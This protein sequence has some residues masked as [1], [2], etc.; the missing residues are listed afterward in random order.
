MKHWCWRSA[1]SCLALSL[2]VGVALVSG[3]A[4]D[5]RPKLPP[6]SGPP[7][8][9]KNPPKPVK[10]PTAAPG[11]VRTP[12]P[13]APSRVEKL[14]E[15]TLRIGAIYVD[16]TKKEIVVPG[17]IN[18]VMVLE[19]LVNTK[20]G[21]KS[22]ESAIEADCTALDFNV[23]LVLIGLDDERSKARPRFHF[24]PVTPQGD[25]V[26]MSVSWRT[27]IGERH[28]KLEELIYNEGNKQTLPAGH[29]VY[30]G[31]RFM[32]NS[33]ALMADVDGVLIGFVHTPATLIERAE[34]VPGPYGNAKLNPALG[35]TAGTP[36]LVTIKALP[37]AAR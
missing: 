6:F 2:T 13:S 23:A 15:S 37:P 14:S 28:A 36:V 17:T 5:S 25:G 33:K 24:D 32:P 26:E 11:G 20:A 34:A 27:A 35:L 19:F 10:P 30:T 4:T 9:M 16:L 1:V 7:P 18:D 21:Y 3:Q 31:P 22:Y 29:W 8:G 12:P